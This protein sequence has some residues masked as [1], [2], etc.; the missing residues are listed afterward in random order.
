VAWLVGSLMAIA[1]ATM[2]VLLSRIE[3]VRIQT[4]PAPEPD[5]AHNRRHGDRSAA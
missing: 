5:P 3:R 4:A 2:G 1:A